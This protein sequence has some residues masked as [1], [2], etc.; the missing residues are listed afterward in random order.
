MSPSFL[1]SARFS[2]T[3]VLHQDPFLAG[4]RRWRKSG[5]SFSS[6]AGAG[7]DFALAVEN[8]DAVVAGDVAF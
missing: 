5:M 4:Y 6:N 1:I 8:D 7:E 3:V 2:L